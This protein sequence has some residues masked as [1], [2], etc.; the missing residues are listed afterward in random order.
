M[1]SIFVYSPELAA[2]EYGMDHPFKP[3]RASGTAPP[4]DEAARILVRSESALRGAAL[5]CGLRGDEAGGLSE[6]FLPDCGRR[7]PGRGLIMV[8]SWSSLTA[9]TRRHEQSPSARQL[10][11]SCYC[12]P[13][14]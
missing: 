14:A 2:I 1:Q 9:D 11:S 8:L 3:E 10:N 4:V 12:R 6:G 7:L 5:G 13:F